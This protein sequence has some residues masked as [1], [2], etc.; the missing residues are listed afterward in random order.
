MVV[1]SVQTV[2]I[3]SALE[4]VLSGVDGLRAYRY[5]ADSVRV[6]AAV[7]AL[8]TIDYADPESGF[9]TATWSFGIS[10]IVSRSSD[11]ASQDALSQMVS[12]VVQALDAAQLDGVLAVEVLSAVPTSITLNGQDLPAYTVRVQVRA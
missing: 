8:P 2:D 10:I 3:A 9:C 1:T 4:D 5:V 7:V 11:R 6:P 12:D